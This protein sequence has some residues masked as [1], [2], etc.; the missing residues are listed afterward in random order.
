MILEVFTNLNDSIIPYKRER[1]ALPEKEI[2]SIRAVNE[3]VIRFL[4]ELHDFSSF[5]T[6]EDCSSKHYQTTY[7]SQSYNFLCAYTRLS[8]E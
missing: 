1:E 4:C 6:T 5:E 2:L 8:F 3:T 7:K